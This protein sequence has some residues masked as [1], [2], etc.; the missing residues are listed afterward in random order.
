MEAAGQVTS[1]RAVRAQRADLWRHLVALEDSLAT[2]IPGRATEW[3]ERVHDALTD[4]AGTFERHV[5]LTEGPGGLFEEVR[6][7]A[8]RLTG[9]IETLHA[10]HE[11]ISSLLR[12][13]LRAARG[14]HDAAD[15]APAQEIRTRLTELLTLLLRHRQVGADLLYEAYA[16]DVGV[17]D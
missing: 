11:Q 15:L 7:F 5:A 3:A 9:S 2:P 13:E 8:P 16:V 1:L 12:Q 4:L 14:I 6:T 10:E 17:G